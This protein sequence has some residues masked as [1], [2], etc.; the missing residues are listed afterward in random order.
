MKIVVIDN[1]DSFIYNLVYLTK[2]IVEDS[3]VV[4][5]YRNDEI[6]IEKAQEYDKIIVGPGPGIPSE[7]GNIVE[8]INTLKESH[9]ILGVCL[10]HQAIVEAYGGTIKQLPEV[11]HGVESSCILN[12]EDPLFAGLDNSF[13]VGRYHSWAVDSCPD[14]FQVIAQDENG[15]NMSIAHKTHRVRGVQFH[16]ESIL[17]PMG[18]QI[19]HN[20]IYRPEL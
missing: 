19:M 6:S 3:C 12:Q 5:V 8:L 20:Y 4:D 11:F 1:Y 15:I 18:Y 17:T 16:P 10:G 14:N 9:S 13:T 7:A 2:E